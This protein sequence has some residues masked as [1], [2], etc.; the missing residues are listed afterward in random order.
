MRRVWR[1]VRIA[2]LIVVATP[3]LFSIVIVGWIYSK[4]KTNGT[5]ITSGATRPYL[6][7]V[8]PSYDPSQPAPLVISMHGAAGWAALQRDIS[9]W[10]QLADQHGFLVVYPSGAR[11]FSFLER[12]PR[13]W[14]VK[15]GPG[16]DLDVR[17]ISDLIDKVSSTYNIDPTR[18]Y[19]DGLSNGGGMAF[20]VGCKLANRVAAV[21]EVAAAQTLAYDWC[22]NATPLPVIK[23]HGTADPMVP[24]R[25]GKSGDPFNPLLFPAVHDWVSSWAKRN[26]CGDAVDVKVTSMTDKLTY[27]NCADEADVVLYTINGGGHAWPGGMALPQWWVGKTTNDIDA[28]RLMWEFFE[29]HRRGPK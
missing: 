7:Y 19:A 17:Y 22:H 29:Q 18:I 15:D 26:R 27:T 14:R 1:V 12:G 28:T 21:G 24:Y 2:L 5:V 25:G 10:N 6:L 4:D 23:F 8:P 16:V 11:L 20:V 13:A 3:I 9:H